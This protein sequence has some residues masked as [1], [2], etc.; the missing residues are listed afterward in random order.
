MENLQLEIINLAIVV[1]TTLVGWVTKNA[2]AYLKKKGIISKLESN[3]ALVKIAVDAVEQTYKTL[4]GKEKFNM[5]KAEV[6][7]LAQSK[8]IKITEKE[9]DLLIESVVKEMNETIKENK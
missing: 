4:H 1:I 6:V 7:E 8:G 2:V 3:K 9:I 5:A